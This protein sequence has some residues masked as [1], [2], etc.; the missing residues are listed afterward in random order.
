MGLLAEDVERIVGRD[1]VVQLTD[2]ANDGTRDDEVLEPII[3]QAEDI[4]RSYLLRGFS[5]DQIETLLTADQALRVQV[6][7]VVAE[8]LSER[9]S[10]FLGADGKGRYWAQYERALDYFDRVSK[11]KNF[12]VGELQT[13]QNALRGGSVQPQRQPGTPTFT[14]GPSSNNPYGSGGF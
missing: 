12:S 11:A 1:T 2:D 4:A 8:L 10:A 14:F 7:W 5:A 3:Q 13:G 6:A 9:R